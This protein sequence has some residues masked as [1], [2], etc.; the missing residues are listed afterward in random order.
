[1]ALMKIASIPQL[2]R[3]LRRWT[4]ILSV[5][6]KYGLADWISRLH[7]E[8]FKDQLKD[9]HGQ[10]LARL[11]QEQRIRLALTELGP[12]FIKFGQLL[13]T[14][15]DIVGVTL[16]EELR[17][18]QRD[19]PADPP[20]VVRQLLETELCAP[21]DELFLEFDETPFAS[22]SIGQVHHA[23]LKGGDQVVVKVQ[24][25]GIQRK[26]DVDLDVLAGLAALADRVPEFAP[27]R[28]TATVAEIAR[29]LRRELDFSREERNLL[30]FSRCF[31]HRTEVRCPLPYSE[32]C[33]PR[34]LTMERLEG[35]S[36]NERSRLESSAADLPELARRGGRL[37]LEMIFTHG[38]YH[39]DPHPGNI[40][41]MP[42]NVLGL[43]DFGMVGR[44]D[45]QLREDIEAMLMSIVQQDVTL[46]TS[47]IR[48]VGKAPPGLKTTALENDVADF[49][50][51]YAHQPLQ[52]FR[53]AA[54][55]QEMVEILRTHGIS[56]PPEVG[57]LIKVLVTLEG[58]TRLLNPQF[59]LMELMQPF[60]RKLLLR[61]LSP[62]HRI[63]KL[64][65]VYLAFEQLA[66]SLP[67][68]IAEILEQVQSGKFDVHLDHRG[69]E[70]S[71]NRL[72]LGMLSSALFLG[73]T[74]LLSRQVP[75]VLFPQNPWY[76]GLYRVSVFGIVGCTV[77][78]LLG[79]RVLRAITK[80]GRLDRRSELD[81]ERAK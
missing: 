22:A 72:V 42:N 11:T 1:M 28:P 62:Q 13:S 3:N 26:V 5:L 58:T 12:T 78:I 34:V 41:I 17:Q 2:Y 59:N 19:T 66:E 75:P 65:R 74:L 10:A 40:L 63:R 33:T 32:Y 81:R 45:E 77:S 73:S 50:A 76:L 20:E 8:R 64:R 30:Q 55:L 39:A 4:E 36:L 57:L 49:V 6:S 14:R 27:Y 35:I 31:R 80:S 48:R 44:L 24:H 43:I 37:Y 56:L 79:L 71:V 18:L 61:R 54:A 47:L 69:L 21:L 16:A 60:H 7:I 70:P 68:R 38:F 15:P 29:T 23:R 52:Q 53:L 51:A 46:L 9:R 25:A 67:Q